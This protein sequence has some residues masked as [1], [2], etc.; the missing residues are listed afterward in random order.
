[1]ANR[2]EAPVGEVAPHAGLPPRLVELT[3]PLRFTIA[4]T[5]DA[6]AAHRHE[7]VRCELRTRADGGLRWSLDAPCHDDPPPGHAAGQPLPAGS[8]PGL[9]NFEVVELMLLGDDNR[10]LEVEVG[11][12]GHF[13]VLQLHGVRRVVE[14]GLP[15]ALQIDRPP[16]NAEEA[17]RWRATVD[18]PASLLPIGVSR[19]NA[20]AI[21]GEGE[22]RRYL[23]LSPAGGKIADFHVLDTFLTIPEARALSV[24]AL[25]EDLREQLGSDVILDDSNSLEAYGRDRTRL[26]PPAPC[27]VALPRRTADV[28]HIVRACAAAGVA[29]V[30]SGGRTGL[31]GGAIAGAGELVLSLQRMQAIGPV[32]PLGRTV[33]V[34]AGATNQAVQDAATAAGLFW[35]VDLASKGSATVGGNLAT[36]A[37]GV[38]V[39]RYGHARHHVLS[40]E[41]VLADGEVVQTGGALRKDN[42]GLDLT[43]LF[44]GSEGT[45][46][47]ITAATLAL[48]PVPGPVEVAL[49]AVD[50]LQSALR[51]LEVC[52]QGPGTLNAFEF[53][54]DRCLEAVLAH[55]SRRAAPFSRRAPYYALCELEPRPGADVHGFIALAAATPGVRDATLGADAGQRRGLWHLREGI[56]EALHARRPHK[57][58][59]SLPIA[60]LPG[61]VEALLDLLAHRRDFEVALFGHLGDGNLHVN[62][63]APPEMDGAALAAALAEAD[64][65]LFRLVV[66]HGGSISAEHGIGLLKVDHLGLQRDPAAL[67]VMRAVKEALDPACLL[68]P[69]KV[70]SPRRAPDLASGALPRP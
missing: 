32:D 69:G 55:G 2:S 34:E 5:F 27:A 56:S 68:N 23:A 62:T 24:R 6:V 67:G 28:A 45:L 49:F 39:I 59:V 20:F 11:P 30:P 10:Y 15:L 26:R 58:D 43:Q 46:G 21:H 70:L 31:A 57:N 12:H 64:A 16:F 29:I 66:A 4:R 3:Q 25:I 61:F 18:L 63:L 50:D 1:M 47:V 19:F 60:A 38:R 14:T 33:R 52:R 9:W 36:N 53:F 65:E 7:H 37:G 48:Q 42:T 44:V 51:L 17:P 13:L 54:A 8:T 35:P 41:V 22:A 40:L